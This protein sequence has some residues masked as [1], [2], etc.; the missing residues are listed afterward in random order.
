MVRRAARSSVKVS[1]RT[2][3]QKYLIHPEGQDVFNGSANLSGSSARQR[4][5][6][7]SGQASS[8]LRSGSS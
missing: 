1:S 4:H 6:P 2:M 8:S 7:C 5:E 3:H